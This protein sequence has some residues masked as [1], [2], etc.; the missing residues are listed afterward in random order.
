[1]ALIGFGV[2]VALKI[3]KAQAAALRPDEIFIHI[4]EAEAE[5]RQQHPGPLDQLDKL[6]ALAAKHKPDGVLAVLLF[7]RRAS[8]R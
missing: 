2:G 8:H 3:R 7:V 4:L 5:R 6:R 1:M